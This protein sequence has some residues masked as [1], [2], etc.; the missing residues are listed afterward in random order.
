[1]FIISRFLGGASSL[2]TTPTNQENRINDRENSILLK[3]AA[4]IPVIGL[5][6]NQMESKSLEE[7]LKALPLPKRL[8]PDPILGNILNENATPEEIKTV[9]K[10]AIQ[11]ESIERDYTKAALVNSLLTIALAVSALAMNVIPFF[12]GVIFIGEFSLTTAIFAFVLYSDHSIKRY[13]KVSASN[14]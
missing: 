9:C 11:L 2:E 14:I 8:R 5:F 3:I 7:K 4:C 10:R 1:M 13:E 6:I 12:V